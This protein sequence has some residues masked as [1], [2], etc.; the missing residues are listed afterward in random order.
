MSE[1]CKDSLSR[2]FSLDTGVRSKCDNHND[3]SSR[4]LGS[5]AKR[6]IR[7]RTDRIEFDN[8]ATEDIKL[9]FSNRCISGTDTSQLNH[10]YMVVNECEVNQS[11]K[12]TIDPSQDF[13]RVKESVDSISHAC[14]Y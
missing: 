13:D 5:E 7:A 4:D 6:S 1:H 11:T 10:V 9:V 12:N 2:E 8:L 3:G 14:R